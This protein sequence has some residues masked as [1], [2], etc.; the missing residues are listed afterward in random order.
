MDIYRET[1]HLKSNEYYEKKYSAPSRFDTKE[2]IFFKRILQVELNEELRTIITN[3]FFNKYVTNSEESFSRELYMSLDQI[4]YMSGEGMHIG[5]HGYNHYWLGSLTKE[6]QNF[7]IDKSIEF[8]KEAGANLKNWTMC[9][10]YGGYNQGTVSLLKNKGCK[11][12]LTTIPDIANAAVNNRFEL[13]RLDTNDIPKDR[14]E[15]PNLWHQKG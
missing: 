7:E 9:Y 14:Q 3:Y 11:L 15:F 2:V 8:L 5:S 13:P 6:K 10:P 12:A 1:Y 4:K